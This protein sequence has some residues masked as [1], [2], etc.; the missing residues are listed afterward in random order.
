MVKI[1]TIIMYFHSYSNCGDDQRRISKGT[2][3]NITME[4]P[5]NKLQESWPTPM[6]PWRALQSVTSKDGTR[7][8]A[9]SDTLFKGAVFGRD[10]LVVAND[11]IMQRPLLTKNILLGLAELQGV[12]TNPITEEEPGK[13]IHEYRTTIVDG[14]HI[15]GIQKE[16]F[17]S[18][19]H[20]WGGGSTTLEYYGSVDAT[21]L[22]LRTLGKYCL[23]YGNEILQSKIVQKNEQPTTLHQS[24]LHAARWISRK[25]KKSQSGML[26]YMRTNPHGI[27]NQVWKDSDEF[28]V[29]EDGKPANHDTP[30]ASIEVQ[31]YV[32][33]A[34]L[35]A[36]QL[37]PKSGD[38][39]KTIAYNLRDKTIELLWIDE[40]QYFAT[41]IDYDSNNEIRTI[42]TATANA[43][44]LLA[45]H[46]FQDLDDDHKQRYVMSIV[47]KLMSY[48]FL[49]DGGIRSRSLSMGH[50]I[51]HWD[52]HGSF[53]SWPKETREIAS[54]FRAHGFIKL[55]KQLENRL[56]NIV[57]KNRSYP[58]FVYV[59]GWGRVLSVKPTIKSHGEITL[60]N[61]TNNP[62]KTQAWTVSALMATIAQRVEDRSKRRYNAD[63]KS[64][65]S[66]LEADI[67]SQ[68]PIINRHL[69]PFVLHVKYPTYPYKLR[70]Q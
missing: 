65:K 56:I 52:Y 32:Y 53:V 1:F 29:H 58:E 59:D 42:K 51:P 61:S 60:V 27:K 30:I 14:K 36:N 35:F 34:L 26:E 50:V 7:V 49:S 37:S 64:W 18:L 4:N 57:L 11:L 3:I 66:N 69:N 54:G 5:L 48:D 46:F 15:R 70:N 33:D 55:A 23:Q 68:I 43:G 19:S 2:C 10:S 6:I 12:K 40:Q 21:P 38:E 45:T 13:I 25:L 67:L 28:Y 31:G 44:S 22:Y 47:K 9:S 39:F 41:G 16:I 62:E 8:Y 24:A 63:Q 17:E 20:K